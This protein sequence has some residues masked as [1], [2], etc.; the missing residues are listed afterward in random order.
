VT[1][2]DIIRWWRHDQPHPP[3]PG[4]ALTDYAALVGLYNR[5]LYN[6]TTRQGSTFTV[7]A[8]PYRVAVAAFAQWTIG[9][10]VSATII[11]NSPVGLAQWQHTLLVGEADVAAV[12]PSPVVYSPLIVDIRRLGPS[13][14][15][16]INVSIFTGAPVVSLVETFVNAS[17]DYDM[18]ALITPDDAPMPRIMD[19]RPGLSG[20]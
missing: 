13:I 11:F 2:S 7:S 20:R 4:G 12:T 1:I 8:S 3:L 16:T 17:L 19:G 14:Q 5:S 9:S 18:T 10:A 6:R 15:G